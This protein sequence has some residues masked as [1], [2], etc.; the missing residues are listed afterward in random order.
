VTIPFG[1]VNDD[2]TTDAARRDCYDLTAPVT[3]CTR[4]THTPA[5]QQ[6]GHCVFM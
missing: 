5:P 2:A 3:D 1:T 4:E 6:Q